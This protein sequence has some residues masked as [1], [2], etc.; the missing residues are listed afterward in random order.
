MLLLVALPGGAFIFGGQGAIR[1]IRFT[2]RVLR[3]DPNR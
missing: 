3:L 2:F 1:N